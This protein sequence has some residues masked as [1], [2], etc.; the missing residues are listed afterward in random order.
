M[1]PKVS[2]GKDEDHKARHLPSTSTHVLYRHKYVALRY[3]LLF[4]TTIQLDH[5]VDQ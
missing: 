2:G 1:I 5:E 3:L 4:P